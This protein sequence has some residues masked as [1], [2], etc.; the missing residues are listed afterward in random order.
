M[1]SASSPKAKERPVSPTKQNSQTTDNSAK[2]ED[3]ALKVYFGNLSADT[4][5]DQLREFA[6]KVGNV[7]T[8]LVRTSRIRN[9]DEVTQ[10]GYGFAVYD[11]AEAASKAVSTLNGRKMG[12]NEVK[13]ELATP[14]RTSRR[15]RGRGRGRRGS[16]APRRNIG[17]AAEPTAEAETSLE[18][19]SRGGRARVRQPRAR[20]IAE[21]EASTTLLYIGN[22]PFKCTE[23]ELKS[24]FQDYKIADA[25]I[26]RYFGRPQGYGF[27]EAST[28]D[29][30]K[31]IL[32]ELQSVEVGDR[33]LAI[34]AAKE[35]E[36]GSISRRRELDAERLAKRSENDKS[37]PAA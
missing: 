6:S 18:K 19:P 23:D 35:K 28:S 13:V 16:R 20:D 26:A 10:I 2:A 8:V 22:L 29:E 3:Q 33:K 31:R 24:I 34:K 30:Q 37:R 9:D 15:T 25:Y 11:S 12:K 14:Q 36:G 7:S 27:V 17:E 4:S 21:G 5:I 1:E 32:S